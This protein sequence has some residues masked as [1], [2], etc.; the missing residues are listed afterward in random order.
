MRRKSPA[1]CGRVAFD[2]VRQVLDRRDMIEQHARQCSPLLFPHELEVSK[3]SQQ[4]PG[5]VRIACGDFFF[6]VLRLAKFDES[7]DRKQRI[8]GQRR[9]IDDACKLV[10]HCKHIGQSVLIE[11]RFEAVFGCRNR[12]VG[13][14]VAAAELFTRNAANVCFHALEARRQAKAQV[15]P[16]AVDRPQFPSPA[17]AA[18]RSLAP[19]K[20]GHGLQSHPSLR[21]QFVFFFFC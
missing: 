1:A 18:A 13:L 2:R 4:A 8:E 9:R 20:T 14:H 11:N 12:K 10:T 16:L 17:P 21:N 7:A 3:C 6:A 5:D 19:R 15:E